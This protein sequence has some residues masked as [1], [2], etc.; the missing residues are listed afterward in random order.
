MANQIIKEVIERE[1]LE[2]NLIFPFIGGLTQREKAVLRLRGQDKPL[3][4][5]GK[6]FKITRQMVQKIELKAKIKN[7]YSRKIVDTLAEKISEVVFEEKEIERAFNEHF[8]KDKLEWLAFCK[9]L[10]VGK[11]QLKLK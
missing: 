2:K 4:L 5:I 11:E 9:I 10:W 3:E 6:K 8:S 7:E 1:L